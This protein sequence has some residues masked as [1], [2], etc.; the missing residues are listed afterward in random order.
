MKVKPLKGAFVESKSVKVNQAKVES[1]ESKSFESIIS[2][3]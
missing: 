3:K 2:W 1:V